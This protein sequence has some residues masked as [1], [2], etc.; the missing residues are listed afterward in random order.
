M[1]F[2]ILEPQ[3]TTEQDLDHVHGARP[4]QPVRN[5]VYA[6]MLNQR[7]CFVDKR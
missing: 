4:R 1:F 2:H 5:C 3:A 6:V 7:Q